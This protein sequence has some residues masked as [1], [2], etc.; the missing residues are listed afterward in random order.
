MYFSLHPRSN[1][2]LANTNHFLKK[3][4]ML[5]CVGSMFINYKP[6]DGN[7]FSCC[8]YCDVSK[9]HLTFAC[10]QQNEQNENETSKPKVIIEVRIKGD[11]HSLRN[12]FQVE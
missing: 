8:V 4:K 5:M 10:Q 7:L 9:V 1:T 2:K 12:T 6:A 11:L 3:K